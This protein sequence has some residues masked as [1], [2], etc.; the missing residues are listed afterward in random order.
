MVSISISPFLISISL[1]AS[2][3]DIPD[4]IPLQVSGSI[5]TDLTK[6]SSHELMLWGLANLWKDGQEGGYAIRHSRQPVRDLPPVRNSVEEPGSAENFFEKA[7][8]CLFPYDQGGLE[9]DR[10]VSLDFAT[11]I[12]WCL[13]YH[14]RRFRMQ[15]VFPFL[16]FGIVQKREAL[17]NAQ[18]QMKRKNFERDARIMST[19]TMEKLRQAQQEEE[20][21]LP[22]SDPAVRLLREHVHATAGRVVGTDQSRYRM[23]G[24]MRSTT[25]EHGPPSLWVTW[26]PNDHNCPLAQVLMGADIDLDKFD[27]LLGPNQQQRATN[28]AADPYGA[29]KFFHF[30]IKTLLE[31]LVQVKVSK[32]QVKSKPGIFGEVAAYFGTVESQGRGT[33]HLHMLIWLKNTPTGEE[34]SELFNV[35]SFRTKMEQYIK[36]NVRAYLPG[37]ESAETVK[38]IPRQPSAGFARPPHPDSPNY[39]ENV[40]LFELQMV[41]SLQVHTCKVRRCLQPNKHGKL[42]CKRKA[43][44]MRA[45]RDFVTEEGRW[46]PRREYAYMNGWQPAITIHGRCNNDCK[47]LTNGCETKN[48]TFYVTSY[49]AKKQGRNFNLSAILA[50]GFAFHLKYVRSDYVDKICENQR[51]LLFR[52]VHTIN[53]EQELAGCMVQSYLMGWGDVY[54][55]HSY[56]SVYWSSFV[57]ALFAA[58]PDIAA[59]SKR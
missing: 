11:H 9:S 10:P 13:Q 17:G 43:P 18:L 26:N 28:V 50:A 4:V 7:F 47:I 22:P 55:S 15:E 53:R 31:T 19:L 20:R 6:V 23:R 52:L 27:A 35:A 39:A 32:Y 12:R 34:L 44:W 3:A 40:K 51:L 58:F 29:A 59:S 24:Q 25:I 49:A 30:T 1:I 8:P 57:A 46:G 14:D 56:S 42:V 37:L 45:A 2:L 48:I 36:A 5:D 16:C 33:L 54:R 41:R 38:A 21:G